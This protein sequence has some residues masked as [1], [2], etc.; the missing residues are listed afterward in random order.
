MTTRNVHFPLGG[1]IALCALSA[2]A[3]AAHAQ[4]SILSATANSSLTSITIKGA[5]LQPVSGPPLVSLG[6]HMLSVVNFSNA[7]IVATLPAS[8]APGTYDL[9]VTAKGAANFDVTIEVAGATGPAGPAGPTGP[10]GSPGAAGPAGPTG[11]QG[12][13]GS[14]ALPFNGSVASPFPALAIT[15]SSGSAIL[16]VAATGSGVAGQ[17]GAAGGSGTAGVS[18]LGGGSG[19]STG[20]P[21]ISGTG[22]FGSNIG[23][24]GLTGSGATGTNN[25]GNGAYVSG[26]T[27]CLGGHGVYAVGGP[28]GSCATPASGYGGYFVGGGSAGD[29]LSGGDGVDAYAGSDYGVGILAASSKQ[30]G[31]AYTVAGAFLGDVQVYG[32]LSKSGGS[33]QIDHPLDPANKYL[34]HSFVESPDMMNIYNGS[35]TTNAGG[36]ATVALPDWFEALN[37]DFRYQLTVIGQFSQ[38]I[39]ASKVHNNSFS[40][41]TD[42][43]NV[44]VS[45]QVTGIRQDAWANT[46][47]IPV[48]MEK[49]RADQGHY[50]HPELFEHKGEASIQELHHPRPPRP[51]QP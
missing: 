34:Y 42:K 36:N 14:L 47:R 43:P 4:T 35:V 30:S 19:V 18:G 27:G 31:G 40:I 2:I 22:G 5:G 9:A 1:A 51:A 15:N 49:D 39:V 10:Q 25:G 29:G 3:G 38:A 21:G 48:E 32:N 33:F 8:L 26:A 23:G 45:W 20:G 44:E 11:P 37:S 50:L 41:K 16:G 12:P 46:H 7:Q 17:G 6:V 13:S 28:G 24:D